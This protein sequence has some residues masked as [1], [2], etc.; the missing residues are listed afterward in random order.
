[1]LKNATMNVAAVMIAAM[2]NTI[3]KAMNMKNTNIH[4]TN[5]TKKAK[6]VKSAFDFYK[7]LCYV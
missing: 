3:M 2:R 7:A 5:T 6:G 4:L 1:M